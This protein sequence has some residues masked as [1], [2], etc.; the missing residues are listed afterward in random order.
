M[1]QPIEIENLRNHIAQYGA[2]EMEIRIAAGIYRE[3]K[4]P[5]IRTLLNQ[6][7]NKKTEKLEKAEIRTRNTIFW[8]S[9]VSAIAS[10]VSAIAA[11]YTSVN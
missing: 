11:V 8:A 7:Q 2:E 10:A 9:W 6:D 5:V 3:D 4:I 1:L